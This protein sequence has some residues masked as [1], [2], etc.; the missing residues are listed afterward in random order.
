[1]ISGG[2]LCPGVDLLVT[3]TSGKQVDPGQAGELI[4]RGANVI[5]RISDLSPVEDRNITRR[6]SAFG[7]QGGSTV[8][9]VG[10]VK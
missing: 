3:D 10:K 7:N 1:M 9:R 2:R 5:S 6:R 4:A 8:V